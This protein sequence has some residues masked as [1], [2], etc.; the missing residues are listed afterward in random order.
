VE[1]DEKEVQYI[2]QVNAKEI[3][4]ARF[5][6]LVGELDLERAMGESVGEGSATT[7]AMTQ[8]EEAGESERDELVEEEPEAAEKVVKSSTV[9]KRKQKA[10]PTRAKVYGEVDGPVSN[11][12]K[13]S[14]IHC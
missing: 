1:L 11:L 12:P 10:A 9:S 3:D 2:R 8:N 4:K 13:S 5:R 7:Q 6:G 14:S